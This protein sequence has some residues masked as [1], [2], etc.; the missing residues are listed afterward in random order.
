MPEKLETLNSLIKADNF[1]VKKM[2]ELVGITKSV[3]YRALKQKEDIEKKAA[4]HL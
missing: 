3:Y 2:C 4:E 1:S